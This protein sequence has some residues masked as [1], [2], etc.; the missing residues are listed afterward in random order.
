MFD[1][2]IRLAKAKQALRDKRFEDA[3]RLAADPLIE[4]DR[5]AE[6]VR[7]QAER[8]MRA[9]D[10]LYLAGSQEHSLVA[11]TDCVLLVTIFLIPPAEEASGG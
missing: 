8:E 5:R 10:W 2:F 4:H 3:L 7:K 1:R 6:Q 9:G 11:I